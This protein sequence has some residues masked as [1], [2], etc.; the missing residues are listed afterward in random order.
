MRVPVKATMAPTERSM[1]P[2]R[3][4]K[5]IPTAHSPRKELSVKRLRK[6]RREKKPR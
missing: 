4:T 6:T 3:M 1:P 2:A 5:V